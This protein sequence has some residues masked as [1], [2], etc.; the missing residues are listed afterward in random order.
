MNIT[1]YIVDKLNSYGDA[2]FRGN[3]VFDFRQDINGLQ[4]TVLDV[5]QDK[6]EMDNIEFTPVS[7]VVNSPTPYVEKN[8]RTGFVKTIAFPMRIKNGY[9]FD[10]DD[11]TYQALVSLYQ[12]L[13]GSYDTINGM[14]VSFKVTPP[15]YDQKALNGG[16]WYAVMIIDFFMTVI[17]F[18]FFC[19]EYGV[20]IKRDTD[21][22][23]YQLDYLEFTTPTGADE[24]I[25][26]NVLS[27]DNAKSK[28][29]R[30]ATQLNLSFNYHGGELERELY[31]FQ[32]GKGNAKAKYNL[33]AIHESGTY[34]YTI[35]VSNGTPLWKIGTVDRVSIVLKEVD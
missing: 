4:F 11:D 35:S 10:E 24:E 14:K 28:Q 5:K 33:R 13:N 34:D 18:G 12:E 3:Y 29:T 23:Y 30:Y 2:E 19:N 1:N 6:I 7:E 9:M 27:N 20:Y 17:E 15:R 31:A 21:E 26:Q 16:E 32:M 25:T 8:N 22:E